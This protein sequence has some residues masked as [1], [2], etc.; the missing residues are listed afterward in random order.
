MSLKRKGMTAVAMAA[1]TLSLTMQANESCIITS[2]RVHT[3]ALAAES[4]RLSVDNKLVGHFSAPSGWN[5]LTQQN[6]DN[7]TCIMDEFRA[8]G[9]VPT[10]PVASGQTF[11]ITGAPAN[12]YIEVTYDLHDAGD[13]KGDEPNGFASNEFTIFSTISN[14]TVLAAA[15]DIPLNVSDI[16][17]QFPAFPAGE[18]VPA[19]YTA[20]LLGLYGT[21]IGK[22]SGAANGQF[23]TRIKFSQDRKELFDKALLGILHHGDNVAVT[24]GLINTCL[25]GRLQVPGA[26][27]RATIITF[28]DPPEF[29]M[30]SELNVIATV[31]RTGAAADF[32]AGDIKLGLL[33]NFVRR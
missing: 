16:D 3:L 15:G 2:V 12:S 28:D 17:A 20:R 26:N 8:A 23:T 27:R 1:T 25:Y 21:G 11:L 32:I 31:G 5:L 30:G 14:G 13:I 19:N 9:L 6:Q 10:Y 29:P 24:A 18:V 22:G 33:L 7:L 4:I